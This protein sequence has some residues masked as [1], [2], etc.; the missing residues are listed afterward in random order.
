MSKPV[1]W[2]ELVETGCKY[3]IPYTSIYRSV[4]AAEMYGRT[5]LIFMR[6][7]LYIKSD[8]FE[9]YAWN[10]AKREKSGINDKYRMC[11]ERANQARISKQ[12]EQQ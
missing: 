1:R 11:A 12:S 10:R 7:N 6:G 8:W 5:Q 2:I 3:D 4:K 9:R